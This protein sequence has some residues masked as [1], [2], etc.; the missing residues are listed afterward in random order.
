MSQVEKKW[1]AKIG[2]RHCTLNWHYTC[3]GFLC[4]K[5]LIHKM[6]PNI[7]RGNSVKLNRNKQ[8]N[9]QPSNKMKF[10]SPV[11]YIECTAI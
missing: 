8:I 11:L 9:K 7:D 1:E 10:C 5:Q 4:L 3:Q 6:F 2:R